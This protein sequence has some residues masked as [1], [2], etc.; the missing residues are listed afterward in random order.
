V[1]THTCPAKGCKRRV[2]DRYLMC[3]V[4]WRRVTPATQR[5]VY[6]HYVPGQGVAT[7][8]DAYREAMNAAIREASDA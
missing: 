5:A 8:T 6:Q 1:S 4:H 2:E 7:M 3:G